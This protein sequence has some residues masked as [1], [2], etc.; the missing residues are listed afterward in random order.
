[1]DYE[2]FNV[3]RHNTLP[4]LAEDVKLFYSD[5]FPAEASFF[6]LKKTTSA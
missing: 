1:M 4:L 2:E 5:R 6:K 3:Y